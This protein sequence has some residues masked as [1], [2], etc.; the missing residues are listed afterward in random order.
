VNA[1]LVQHGSEKRW[2]VCGNNDNA[3]LGAVRALEGRGFDASN[4][5][6]IGINGTDCIVE[7]R[8]DRPTGFFA[9][10]LLAP[11][12]HGFDT[13]EMMYR[14]VTGGA[15]PL[16]ETYTQGIL[17]TRDTFARVLAEQGLQ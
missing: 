17:I 5:I 12:R 15:E 7:F 3:V 11:K 4:V 8:K 14:W 1:L 13:A 10:I 6:A 9:S 16:K 2:L